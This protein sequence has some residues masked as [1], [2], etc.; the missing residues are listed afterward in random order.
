VSFPSAAVG[1]ALDSAGAL[2]RT[3]DAGA[4]WSTLDTGTT[5]RPAAMYAPTEQRVL[6]FGPTGIRRSNDGGG[7]FAGVRG[8]A[9]ARTRLSGYDRAGS[10]LFAWGQ[11]AL[12]RS[13][14][15]GATWATV[16]DPGRPRGGRRRT[17]LAR[18]RFADFV[19]ARTGYVQDDAGRVFRTADGGRSWTELLGIGIANA[20]AMAFSSARSGYLAHFAF[21]G[22]PGG[23][24]LRTD[25]DGRTWAPQL[26]AA[27]PI[28]PGG[29][30]AGG[31]VDHL[32]AGG[33]AFLSTRSGGRFGDPSRLSIRA[34]RSRLRRP[35]TIRITGR[36]APARG[37]EEV[38]V[39]ARINGRW[40][41]Q[42]A[43]AASSG[44]FTT[45]WRVPRGTSRFVAQWAGDDRLA[46]RGTPVLSVR[47][48]R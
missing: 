33:S 42:T 46:G 4:G 3:A 12:I 18:I 22:R 32:L 13:T 15:G 41:P 27:Q 43:R 40:R 30:A 9:V 8:R 23:Y 24:V 6:L 45:S 34:S 48:G 20:T 35:A 17:A 5:A 16:R 37:N 36:L 19:T 21:G 11:T 47:V 38:V 2:F 14:D 39:S 25:D 10:A 44:S 26:V 29:L 28:V 1:Y 7:D 31:G